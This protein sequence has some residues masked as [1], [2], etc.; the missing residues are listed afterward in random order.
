MEK[1]RELLDLVWDRTTYQL[2]PHFPTRASIW[3]KVP[4]GRLRPWVTAF[5]HTIRRDSQLGRDLVRIERA[6]IELARPNHEDGVTSR[7]PHRA[8][9]SSHVHLPRLSSRTVRSVD[10]LR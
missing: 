1:L 7:D 2:T 5:P 3:S 4:T 10:M 9:R 6:V 8:T